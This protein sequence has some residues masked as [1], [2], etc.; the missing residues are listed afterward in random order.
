[1]FA[2]RSHRSPVFL[3]TG[4]VVSE[5]CSCS[6]GHWLPVTG[7]PPPLR[8]GPSWNRTLL[9][10]P[11]QGH[12]LTQHSSS[13]SFRPIKGFSVF[14]SCINCEEIVLSVLLACY[15]YLYI[16]IYRCMYL[17]KEKKL[18]HCRYKRITT[19][20]ALFLRDICNFFYFW[21]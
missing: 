19:C 1:M 18:T 17:K 21:H 4:S 14:I 10:G 8:R 6:P 9:R 16:Y 13:D 5:A 11:A 2:F 7:G 3:F 15:V 12:R 20:D